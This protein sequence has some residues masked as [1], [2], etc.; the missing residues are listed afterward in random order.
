MARKLGEKE[1]VE[2]L[3]KNLRQEKDALKK[4]ETLSKQILTET[5]KPNGGTT[6]SKP[7]TKARAS[8]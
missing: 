2:L 1:V 8:R 7:R 6:K 3:D 4:V 5:V